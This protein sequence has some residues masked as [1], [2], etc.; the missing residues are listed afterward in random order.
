MVAGSKI[1]ADRRGAAKCPTCLKPPDLQ[2]PPIMAP[3]LL[4][5]EL[6]LGLEVS[7]GE[8]AAGE[9]EA[10]AGEGLG[11]GLAATVG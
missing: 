2:N 6:E 10:A 8:A 4:L 9:G 7:E 1:G 5:P 11:E 3:T